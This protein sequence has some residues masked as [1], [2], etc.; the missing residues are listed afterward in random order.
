VTRA[1]YRHLVTD[2]L[3]V[4]STLIALTPTSASTRAGDSSGTF[5]GLAPFEKFSKIQVLFS[6]MRRTLE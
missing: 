6:E 3:R 1:I 2:T 5:S 4:K